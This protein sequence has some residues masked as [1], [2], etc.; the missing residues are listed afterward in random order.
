MEESFHDI[1]DK[2]FSSAELPKA[3]MYLVNNTQRCKTDVSSIQRLLNNLTTYN[4]TD[5]INECF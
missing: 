3:A 2:A 5:E 4:M 1:V